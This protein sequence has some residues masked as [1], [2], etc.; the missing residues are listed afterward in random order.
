LFIPSSRKGFA[1]FQ[2]RVDISPI[3][4][5][6]GITSFRFLFLFFKSVS[7]IVEC[8]PG[9][10]IKSEASEQ[11]LLLT[12]V[13]KIEGKE[14]R[15]FALKFASRDQRNSILTGLRFHWFILWLVKY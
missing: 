15:I 7:D 8:L 3:R 11:S 14:S 13:A 9:A 2:S 1:L 4:F 5:D 10:E 6:V 12:I